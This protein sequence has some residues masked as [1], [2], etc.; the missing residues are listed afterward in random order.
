M[1]VCTVHVCTVHVCTCV[2][3]P[4]QTLSFPFD[5]IRKKLQA[6][7]NAVAMRH[8][9]ASGDVEF[10]GMW[11]AFRQTYAKHGTV[12]LWRGTTANLLKVMPY[13]GIMFATFEAVK[14]VYLYSN[15]YTE[16]PWRDQPKP[17]VNQALTPDELKQVLQQRALR[18]S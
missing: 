7:H 8:R 6:Q 10:S 17:G 1:P 14:R 13:S 18:L 12:G 9:L 16:S 11:D 3:P 5:T 15:G 4:S 2:F